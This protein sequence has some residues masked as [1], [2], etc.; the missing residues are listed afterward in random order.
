MAAPDGNNSPPVAD[1]L[2]AQIQG[3]SDFPFSKKRVERLNPKAIWKTAPLARDRGEAISRRSRGHENLLRQR[4]IKQRKSA[5]LQPSRV[6][7]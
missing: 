3:S 7:S 5:L 6:G 1:H 4:I 2:S